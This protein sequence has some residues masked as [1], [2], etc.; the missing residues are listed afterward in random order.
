MVNDASGGLYSVEVIDVARRLRNRR[1]Q[2]SGGVHSVR[3]IDV[4][5][6]RC[7]QLPPA[8]SKTR[9]CHG[10]ATPQK[11]KDDTDPGNLLEM[12]E[13]IALRVSEKIK[14]GGGTIP[15]ENLFAAKDVIS[16]LSEEE[17]L[18]TFLAA[19]PSK[20]DVIEMGGLGKW[21]H[22]KGTNNSTA[23]AASANDA[24][25][26]ND[27]ASANDAVSKVTSF[28]FRN[29]GTVPFANLV[30]QTGTLIGEG[31]HGPDALLTW[32]N[33]NVHIFEVVPK[34]DD[35][36]KPW[37]VKVQ[38]GVSPRFCQHYIIQGH[39]PKKKCQFLHIC[40]AFVCK[41]PH[42]NAECKFSHNIRDAHNKVIADKMGALSKESDDVVV[43]VL[44]KSYFPRVCSDYNKSGVCPRGDKC[45]FLHVCGN[46]VLNQCGISC[47]LSH[48]IV[49][50]LHN[51]N[52]LKKYALLP[53]QKLSEELV[54][55]N[56]AFAQVSKSPPGQS[57]FPCEITPKSQPDR[58]TVMK[59]GKSASGDTAEKKKRR[60][61]HPRR[62]KKSS[63]A[64][65]TVDDASSDETD[66]SAGDMDN[67][68]NASSSHNPI[69][70]LLSSENIQKSNLAAP[71]TG[72]EKVDSW[73]RIPA[74]IGTG[75]LAPDQISIQSRKRSDSMSSSEIS[76]VSDQ[77]SVVSSQ[78]STWQDDLQK[79]VFITILGKY[80]GDVPFQQIAKDKE[81]FGHGVNAVKWFEN[82]QQKFILH[83]NGQGKIDSV[84]PF[85]RKARICLDYNE[86]RGC[87]NP[88][89]GFFHICRS[90]IEGDCPKRK[91][92]HLNHD[93]GSDEVTQALKRIGL[94]E[95]T[96]KQLFTLIQVSVPAVCHFHNKGR[97]N[98]GDFC[99]KLHVCKA[100]AKGH[101]F[102]KARPCKFGHEEA[103]RKDPA[104]KVLKMY[105][106]YGKQPNFKYM[107]K[108]IFVFETRSSSG[109]RHSAEEHAGMQAEP[110]SLMDVDITRVVDSPGIQFITITPAPPP[111]KGVY[112]SIPSQCFSPPSC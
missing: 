62:R 74:E 8:T 45:H 87:F 101:R 12:A 48:N 90:H 15:F 43:N 2:F 95:L 31:V 88:K 98:R 19:F 99:P 14:N 3:G 79:K 51:I 110:R 22:L 27:A 50:G 67:A 29:G 33:A 109:R 5:R 18:M 47:P 41:H 66:S 102:C 40:K 25:S 6:H 55:A 46:Y 10:K 112:L 11:A 108:M 64:S 26:T 13:N 28:I 52:L 83:R 70:S 77:S 24:A 68:S 85:S 78:S 65:S 56:I 4:D 104:T 91:A 34:P 35:P 111:L 7:E 97:C 82:H 93:L 96:P 36:T 60:H 81:L 39:C 9:A 105:H 42:N 71:L 73:M 16:P 103:L 23:V 1:A 86:K 53:S 107:K 58:T 38:I 57:I 59:V 72:Y 94:P 61:R 37:Q 80:N 20:F 106:L 21:V 75:N 89:C 30:E 32:L 54:K 63:Q 92:C 100:F 84:S 76:H 69:P 44:L 49:D 17:A